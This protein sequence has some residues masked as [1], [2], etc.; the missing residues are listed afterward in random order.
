MYHF[1][2]LF[3]EILSV[4]AVEFNV[5]LQEKFLASKYAQSIWLRTKNLYISAYILLFQISVSCI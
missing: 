5:M 3:Q 1:L 4:Q 2:F